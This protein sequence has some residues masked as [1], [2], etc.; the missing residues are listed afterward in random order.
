LLTEA[1]QA[2]GVSPFTL[3]NWEW[4][5]TSPRIDLYGRV[6]AFLGFDPNATGGG[7][8]HRMLAFRRR[9]GLGQREAAR[10]LGV[11]PT[12]WRGWES[13]RRDPEGRLGVRLLTLLKSS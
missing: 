10:M 7:L 9:H 11:D 8:R 1:A 3:S 12:T 4:G 6:V 13:G 2:L 5:K